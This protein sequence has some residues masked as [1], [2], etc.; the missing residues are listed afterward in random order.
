MWI[1][2]IKST[3]EKLGMSHWKLCNESAGSESRVDI[4]ELLKPRKT[5]YNYNN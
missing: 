5:Y 3:P 1:L 2:H 4:G